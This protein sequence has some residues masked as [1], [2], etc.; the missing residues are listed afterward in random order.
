M[1]RTDLIKKN[2]VVVTSP[3]RQLS[4]A[5]TGE[6]LAVRAAKAEQERQRKEEED[7]KRVQ[8]KI[9]KWKQV[10]EQRVREWKECRGQPWRK[11][12]ARKVYTIMVARRYGLAV[13]MKF[14]KLKKSSME[15]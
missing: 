1:S 6:L 15:L 12:I 9:D 2:I 11:D 14:L 13:A 7:R 3:G 4:K 5:T 8:E 10:K